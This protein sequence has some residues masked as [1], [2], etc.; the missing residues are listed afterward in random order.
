MKNAILAVLAILLF[1]GTVSATEIISA[2]QVPADMLWGFSVTMS[3][4]DTFDYTKIFLDGTEIATVY[5]SSQFV[6]TPS[7]NGVIAAY[8][9]DKDPK[10]NSGLTFSVSHAGL[11]AGS[12]TIRAESYSG[13]STLDSTEA[14]PSFFDPEE[15]MAGRLDEAEATLAEVKSKQDGMKIDSEQIYSELKAAQE[16]LKA[17]TDRAAALETGMGDY[18]QDK[19]VLDSAK[20]EAARLASDLAAVQKRLDALNAKV[21]EMNKPQPS[22]LDGIFGSGNKGAQT[23]ESTETARQQGAGNAQ[24]NSLF[25]GFLSLSSS[26]ILPIALAVFIVA[27]VIAVFA[28]YKYKSSSSSFSYGS[29]PFS[30]DSIFDNI[31]LGAKKPEQKQGKWPSGKPNPGSGEEGE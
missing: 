14:Q 6:L 11:N 25:A 23:S 26:G 30:S 16:E 18:A 7:A 15:M 8:L 29:D 5:P 10:S 20:A 19:D 17:L 22:L 24:E 13:G 12:H 1:C 3:D 21:S 31:G 27:A 28:Y 2:T 9:Y 4:T